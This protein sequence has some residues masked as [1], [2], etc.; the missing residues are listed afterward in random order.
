METKPGI[1]ETVRRSSSPPV[2]PRAELRRSLLFVPGGEARKL[3]RAEAAGADTLVFDLEDSVEPGSKER[4]RSLVAERLASVTGNSDLVVRV[5][6]CHTSFFERDV[7]EVVT[8]GAR[9]L[10]LPKSSPATISSARLHLAY[11]EQQLELEAGCIRI[12]G[13]VE[14]ANGMAR[15]PHL[16]DEPGRLDALCFGN[17]D[18]SLD[19]GLA[20]S[21]LSLG[22]VSHARCSLAITAVAAGVPPIDGVC[23]AVRDHGAFE[24]EA[25]AALSLGF[26][27]KL[28][29]HPEQVPIANAVFTPTPEQIAWARRVVDAS[30]DAEGS[31]QGVFALDGKMVDAPVLQLQKRLLERAR[32]AGALEAGARDP[33]AGQWSRV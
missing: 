25:R 21:D 11:V 32:R 19:M 26:T 5:N 23:M 28:C 12:L 9:T 33:R 8:A 7:L 27:G 2:R 18:F 15:L 6:G 20:D 13:L 1:P 10:M 22:A 17:A 31:G 29:I 4:A 16:L 30:S 24:S 3:E 14:T